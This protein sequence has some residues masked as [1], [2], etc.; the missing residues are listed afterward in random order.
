MT[1]RPA[2][3]VASRLLPD[4]RLTAPRAVPGRGHDCSRPTQPSTAAS[5][6]HR[7]LRRRRPRNSARQGVHRSY[8]ST[9]QQP[10]LT[11]PTPSA[12]RASRRTRSG[13]SAMVLWATSILGSPTTNTPPREGPG[14]ARRPTQQP[15]SAPAEVRVPARG[16][17]RDRRLRRRALRAMTRPSCPRRYVRRRRSSSRSIVASSA[18]VV[19]RRCASEC[20][21]CA[22]SSSI[23]WRSRAISSASGSATTAAGVASLIVFC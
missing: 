1:T 18:S 23:C 21:R 10:S 16:R 15:A 22:V 12:S 2:L 3:R 11:G 20:S 13:G 4:Q 7:T 6:D 17:Q 5:V 9:G 14:P 8:A 19:S